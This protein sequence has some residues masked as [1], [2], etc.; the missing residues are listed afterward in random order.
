MVVWNLYFGNETAAKLTVDHVLSY[1]RSSPT[2]PYHGGARSWG[3]V[4]NNGKYLATFGT[5]VQDRGQMRAPG[6]GPT[7]VCGLPTPRRPRRVSPL[8]Q[9]LPRGPKHDPPDRVVPPP[10]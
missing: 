10:P 2:W 9:A 4:G 7:T 5:G 6:A 1:M 8:L 3:D